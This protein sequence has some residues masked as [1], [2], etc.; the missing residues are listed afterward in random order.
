MGAPIA[1]FAIGGWKG[2]GIPIDDTGP[3]ISDHGFIEIHFNMPGSGRAQLESG[4]EYDL[5]GMNCAIAFSDVIRFAMG[6]KTDSEG[7]NL[8]DYTGEITPMHNNTGLLGLSNG[9]NLT[10][11]TAGMFAESLSGLAWIVN[12][13]S[14]V[15]DGIP[16][17]IAG[18]RG[19]PD[20]DPPN[21]LI[22]PA[23]NPADHTFDWDKLKYSGDVYFSFDN[24]KIEGGLYFDVNDNS[25][26][27]FGTD[28]VLNGL[29]YK[30]KVYYTAQ[31]VYEAE[32]R[33]VY[34]AN[35][36]VHFPAYSNTLLFWQQRNGI[37]WIDT[38]GA[39]NQDI[40]FIIEA[41]DQ[42]H[43]QTAP[44]HPHIVIQYNAFID[45]GAKFVRLNPDRAY[46]NDILG[47]EQPDARDNPAFMDIDYGNV[48][49]ALQPIGSVSLNVGIYAS[50]CEL[51]DRVYYGNYAYNL[52]EV[53]TSPWA[54]YEEAAKEI[55]VY[56]NPFGEYILFNIGDG[57]M[58]EARIDIYNF[59]GYRVY[60]ADFAGRLRWEACGSDGGRLPAGV[61]HYRINTGGELHYGRIV[62]CGGQ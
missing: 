34:P 2:E 43:V 44:N 6:L 30:N 3:S 4:G 50:A 10:T 47:R 24:T 56:P 25:S 61:Y 40:L 52:D 26:P 35:R 48:V 17:A 22:N 12:W 37:Y 38:I 29:V 39:Y 14:P 62:Y 13:E 23:Y 28:Y 53:I 21:P 33:G 54:V 57:A 41:A 5:R 20:A 9:G 16:T 58:S 31:A 7:Q 55:E 49:G 45:A 32:L 18:N 42:D 51:A 59:A 19:G 46:V 8:A 11:V 27:D 36:P 15:G 1:V 60:S